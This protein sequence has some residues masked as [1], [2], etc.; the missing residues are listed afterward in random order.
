MMLKKLLAAATRVAPLALLASC[1]PTTPVTSARCVT[2]DDCEKGQ[3]C[4]TAV[5]IPSCQVL[6]SGENGTVCSEASLCAKGLSCMGRVCAQR[7]ADIHPGYGAQV[8][9]LQN[10]S[11][12]A[13]I[14][15][16]QTDGGVGAFAEIQVLRSAY[17]CWSAQTPEVDT[18]DSIRLW[19]RTST[20][21]FESLVGQ[22]L[23]LTSDSDLRMGKA[24]DS[25]ATV[26]LD[27]LSGDSLVNRP[28]TLTIDEVTQEAVAGSLRVTNSAGELID[29]WFW[30]PRC[31]P[32]R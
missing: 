30:V 13:T 31:P 25:Y 21:S 7:A 28:G 22:T 20:G 9:G 5:E 32:R 3:R 1:G 24:G 14:M 26:S 29:G 18:A 11:G 27:Q 23:E 12:Q 17:A 4:N 2:S 19:V 10:G 16:F 15:A 8:G 6:Y